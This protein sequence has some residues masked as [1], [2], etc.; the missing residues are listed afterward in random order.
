MMNLSHLSASL[1][2]LPLTFS[3]IGCGGAGTVAAP[4]E[5]PALSRDFGLGIPAYSTKHVWNAKALV[6]QLVIQHNSTPN[7]DKNDYTGTNTNLRWKG[8]NGYT[9]SENRSLC[10]SFTSML[11]RHAFNKTENDFS[12]KLGSTSPYAE[13]Y[14]GFLST[15]VTGWFSAGF[16]NASQ[17]SIGDIIAIRYD[18][19]SNSSG[20]V[21]TIAS[22]PV[23]SNRNNTQL[24]ADLTVYDSS[25]SI[26]STDTRSNGNQGAG[27]GTFRLI[28]HKTTKEV[29]AYSWSTENAST[30]Y[31]QINNCVR[32]LIISHVL[33]K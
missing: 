21:M 5:S 32:P 25:S 20:H 28:V 8:E 13:D 26:H 15:G 9:Y 6:D 10:A 17:I 11:L 19:N 7:D 1:M 33:L 29:E 12:A 3:L 30:T 22:T 14:Y 16:L 24:N 2:L 18:D 4:Q 31:S 23:Y 27:R